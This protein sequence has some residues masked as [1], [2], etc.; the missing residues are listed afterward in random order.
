[1][2]R[3][4]SLFYAARDLPRARELFAA[5]VDVEFAVECNLEAL[6][7]FAASLSS[8]AML[9]LWPAAGLS[10]TR[11]QLEFTVPNLDAAAER[12]TRAG[13]EVRRLAGTVLVI[14]PAGNSVALTA[15]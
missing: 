5:A 8:G 2:I 7:Y 12:L 10:P 13:F 3:R 4:L 14:D 1:M 15:A 11:V 9:E 6:T